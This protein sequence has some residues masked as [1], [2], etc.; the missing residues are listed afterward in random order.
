MKKILNDQEEFTK[1]YD[2]ALKFLSYRPRS[3]KELLNWFKKKKVSEK[4]QT[5]IL[6]RLKEQNLVNDEEFVKWWIEQR[7]VFKPMGKYLIARELKQKGIS[8]N[9]IDPLLHGSTVSLP[10]FDLAKKA[11]EKKIKTYKNLPPLEFRQKLSAFL[12]RRGFSWEIVNDILSDQ[13]PRRNN[14]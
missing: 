6:L 11:A 3:E 8:Q 10:E 14:I 13:R 4:T 2:R 7:T 9:I 12:A 5:L 1:F